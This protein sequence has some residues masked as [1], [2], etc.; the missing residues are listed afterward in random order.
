M[1]WE[2]N[3][4]CRPGARRPV[5]F[6]LAW[7]DEHASNAEH[8]LAAA[9][10]EVCPVKAQCD[11]AAQTGREVGMVWGGRMRSTNR[12]CRRCGE[13]TAAVSNTYCDECRAATSTPV[14]ALPRPEGIPLGHCVECVAQLKGKQVR[15]CSAMC[16]KRA[17]LRRER[18]RKRAAKAV[19]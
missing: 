14:T 10:C 12:P 9:V 1:R 18:D 6:N 19:A 3:A 7:F 15:Y 2:E 8:A 13:P 16:S 11:A 17:R 5:P 4:L